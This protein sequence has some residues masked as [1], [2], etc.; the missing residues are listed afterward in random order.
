MSLIEQAAKRLEALRKA[1]AELE[2]SQAGAA[3]SASDASSGV[4]VPTPEAAMRELEARAANAGTAK[5]TRVVDRDG[6]R[7]APPP[8]PRRRARRS[9]TSRSTSS[10]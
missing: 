1:G 9:R 8:G 7:G 6:K 3:P 2:E 5:S 4:V 10:G